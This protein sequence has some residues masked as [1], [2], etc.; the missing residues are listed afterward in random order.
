MCDAVRFGVSSPT[1][2]ALAAL[3]LPAAAVVPQVGLVPPRP[4]VPGHAPVD[5]GA[6]AE[7]VR[8]GGRGRR[9]FSRGLRRGRDGDRLLRVYVTGCCDTFQLGV[10]GGAEAGGGVPPQRCR[11]EVL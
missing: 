4:A 1:L 10:V 8:D 5:G 3:A 11:E 2:A 6:L 9:G 7:G